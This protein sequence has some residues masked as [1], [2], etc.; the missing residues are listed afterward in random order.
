MKIY[1]NTIYRLKER[2]MAAIEEHKPA[3]KR[4]A[5]GRGLDSLLPSGPRVVGPASAAAAAPAAVPPV[6][7]GSAAPAITPVSG[8]AIVPQPPAAAGYIAEL[9]AAS[10][11]SPHALAPHGQ[12]IEVPLDLI[13]E[14]PYQTRRTFD[15]AALSELAESIKASGL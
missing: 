8:P 4:R 10:D 1:R 3:E 5:L 6:V 2:F 14:N 9:H 12:V 7:T 15:P 13:D 11:K